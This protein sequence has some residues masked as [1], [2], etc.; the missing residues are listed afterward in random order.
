M[1]SYLF[2]PLDCGVGRQI[3]FAKYLPSF[4]WLPVVLTVKKSYLRPKY[5]PSRLEEIPKSVKIYRTFSFESPPLQ[6]RVPAILNKFGINPKWLLVPDKF[7]GWLPF[8][9]HRGLEILREEKVDVIFS[10]S[11]PNTCHLVALK[12][13]RKTG[14]PWV[15]DF[16]DPWTQNPYLTYPKPI[17]KIEEPMEEAVIRNADKVTTT[18]PFFAKG[19]IRKYSEE[20][21]EKFVTIQHGFDPDDLQKLE[22]TVEPKFVMTYT[23]SLYGLRKPDAFLKAVSE[24]L[25]EDRGLKDKLKIRFVG[26]VGRRIKDVVLRYGLGDTVE[27]CGRVSHKRALEYLLNSSIIL[28]ITGIYRRKTTKD[29]LGRVFDELPG[30]LPEYI[31][32]GRPVLA[33]AVSGGSVARVIESTGTGIVVHP[34]DEQGIKKAVRYFYG[35]HQQGNLKIEPNVEEIEKYDIR[36]STKRLSKVFNEVVKVR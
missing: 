36:T 12:L 15:A 20:P 30:K 14:L 26:S 31:A 6:Q 21:K 24:L 8:A 16:R 10:T 9:V 27:I 17:L 19:F 23:G 18:N 3:K 1:I 4:G 29:P 32:I 25:S 5:D 35:L 28:L 22:T 7:I 2:S 34:R 33:L 11:L 13:K